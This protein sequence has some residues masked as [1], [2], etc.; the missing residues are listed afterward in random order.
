MNK[1]IITAVEVLGSQNKLAEAC[2][3]SQ[4]SVLKWINGGGI[5]VENAKKIEDATEGKVTM[6]EIAEGCGNGV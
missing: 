6:R 4:P 1:A 3:V 5:S 2:N